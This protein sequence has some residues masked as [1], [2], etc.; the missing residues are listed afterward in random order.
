M[1]HGK[2]FYRLVVR[3]L[4]EEPLR[5]SLT[6]I[7][8]AL[9]IAAVLAI[10]LAGQAAAGSFQSSMQSLTGGFDF[11]VTAVGGV[12]PEALAR[13]ARLPYAL[14]IHPR[15]EDY[16][17]TQAPARSVP[18]V[19][20]DFLSESLPGATGPSGG[21]SDIAGF[22]HSDSVWVGRGLGHKA[23]DRLSLTIN[24]RRFEFTVRGV[25]GNGS[26]EVIVMDLAPVTQVLG[27]K[28]MLDRILVEV[29]ESAPSQDWEA[30]LRNALPN[31]VSVTREGTRTDENRRMLAAFRW[32]LRVLSYIA[33]VVGAFL[34]YNTISISVVRRHTEIGILR[35]LGATH[36]Q[37]FA[38]FLSEA[39]SLGLIGAIAGIALGRLMAEGAVKMV[40]ATV[41]SLYVSSRPGAILLTFEV[42]VLA[43]VLGVAISTLSALAP[44]WEA[45]L[46]P[47]V[48]A[49][50]RGR[51]EYDARLH[52]I[53]NLA[54]AAVLAAG[55]WI[56]SRQQPVGG[57]PIFGYLSALSLIGA[58]AFAVPSLVSALSSLSASAMFRVFGV[59]ALLASRS[60]AGSLRRTSVLVGA[61]STAIAM[62][63]AVGIMVGSFRETVRIWM[64]DRLQADL[65]LQA[66]VPAGPDRHSTV[67]AEVPQTLTKL[68][69][70]A[71]VDSF[72]A[73]DISYEGLPAVVGGGDARIAQ[74]YG[75]RP[76]LS[77]RDPQIVF[78]QLIASDKVIVSEPFANKHGVR[79]GSMLTLNL[80]D[81]T[82]SFEVIDV[83]YDYS[84]E[85]GLIIMDRGTLLKYLPDAA[86]SNI[87]V[88]LKPGTSLD[89][90]RRA[91][92]R[93][94]GDRRILVLSN[95]SLRE[96]ALR[97]FD[98][99]FA[100]TYAL[101]GVA[102]FVAIIGV[103]GA[104]LAL[105][106]DRRRELGLLRF[107]GGEGSQLR[108]LILF[109]AGFLG[110]LANLVGLI[111]GVV[112]SLLLIYVIN[113][114]SFGW[115]IQFHWPVTVLL[116]AL[117]VVFTATIVAGL[118][119]ARMAMRL[120]PIE[121][122]HEE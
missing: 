111:L 62:L 93:A 107:L 68:P 110:L 114:Q 39:A 118:Y 38:A 31:G 41:S 82:V 55:A 101:E 117:S 24:D 80:G 9:G 109:E 42:G 25:L 106:I 40:G 71:A 105:V 69:E 79:A 22:E 7:S 102:V 32:N 45:S 73:Y 78:S 95:R 49:M 122:I 5:T 108:R 113:K 23:G 18:F 11:E 50:A 2:L 19:G 3:P 51:V 33:L 100:I 20:I 13:L 37:V 21:I 43:V 60:L 74:R 53:R 63:V 85:R 89:R 98:R 84:S 87:A 58:S 119:P 26:G 36:R 103:S 99:T 16:A 66:A 116:S 120:V 56:A 92:E 34:I 17:V 30:I 81:K 35:A 61:L 8:V 65:Y 54:F 47:P 44:A 28:G 72:R 10:E 94:I 76:F 90:G 46:V 104:L 52:R 59:E 64:E 12:P 88:Y 75:R 29:P 27:R 4:R 86:P 91:I 15:I 70:V 96:E 14:K 6:V 83:Y 115:T 48:E 1:H 121:V 67:S 112:L 97:I 77:G 57:K